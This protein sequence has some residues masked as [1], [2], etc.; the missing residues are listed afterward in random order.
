MT[1]RSRALLEQ[2]DP[3]AALVEAAHAGTF[4][5]ARTELVHGEW[6]RRQRRPA[7]ARAHL[8]AALSA[9]DRLGAAPWAERART[10]LRAA[11]ASSEPA[12]ETRGSDGSS[13]GVERAGVETLTPQERRIAALAADGLSNRDIGARLYLSPRT[14]GYHLYKAYPKLGVTGRGELAKLELMA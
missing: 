7:R 1:N 11:G 6:L 4:E 8:R 14:V 2:A 3:E 12:A 9:F 13:A 5:Q 10:E